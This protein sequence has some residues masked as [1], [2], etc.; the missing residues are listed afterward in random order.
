V[1]DV[2]CASSQLGHAFGLLGGERAVKNPTKYTFLGD[3]IGA[4]LI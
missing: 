2:C 4:L 1:K 3:A